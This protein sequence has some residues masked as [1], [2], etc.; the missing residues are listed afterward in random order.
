M[1]SD[2]PQFSD[3]NL[4]ARAATIIKEKNLAQLSDGKLRAIFETVRF[5]K[6][7]NLFDAPFRTGRSEPFNILDKNG[8]FVADVSSKKRNARSKSILLL[9]LLNTFLISRDFETD[10]QSQ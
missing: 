6:D 1:N 8:R 4:K 3:E 7:C 2:L 5:V 9:E 10:N